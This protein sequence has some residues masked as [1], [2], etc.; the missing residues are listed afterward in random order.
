MIRSD[1]AVVKKCISLSGVVAGWADGLAVKKGFDTNYSAYIAD[2][3]RRD[4]E[5]DDE[6]PPVRTLPA[7]AE[8][9]TLSEVSSPKKSRAADAIVSAV[10]SAARK[11][12]PPSRK[13]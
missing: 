13:R 1:S 10:Q 2:L 4:K 8:A 3:I 5:R 9:G 6:L 7:R 11:K 12:V